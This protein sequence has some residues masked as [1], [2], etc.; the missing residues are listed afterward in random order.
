[1]CRS[2]LAKKSDHFE[3]FMEKQDR[4]NH[5]GKMHARTNPEGAKRAGIQHSRTTIHVRMINGPISWCAME[6][7]V[8]RA[9]CRMLFAHAHTRG[10]GR[11]TTKTPAPY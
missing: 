4:Y 10:K 5:P 9:S 2:V 3:T 6:Q 7:T 11:V 1:M 8:C